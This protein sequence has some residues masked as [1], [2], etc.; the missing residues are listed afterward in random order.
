M[1]KEKLDQFN[2]KVF[3]EQLHTRFKVHVDARGPLE[4]ELAEVNE[5]TT[6]PQIEL[7]TLIFRGPVTPRLMQQ[8]HQLEH[9][10]LGT[11][12][13]FLTP[14]GLDGNGTLYEAVFHRFSKPQP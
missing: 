12:D 3:S 2:A 1:E 11:F 13:I 4:L 6:S 5:R 14:V 9:G 8:T 7:F 10:T